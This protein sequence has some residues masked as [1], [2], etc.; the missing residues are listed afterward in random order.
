MQGN[1]P[2]TSSISSQERAIG[3]KISVG[4]ALRP[5][6]KTQVQNGAVETGPE[7][8]ESL[9]HGE[10]KQEASPKTSGPSGGSKGSK[11]IIYGTIVVVLLLWTLFW[12]N[13]FGVLHLGFLPGRG[14]S[15]SL[16]PPASE[17]STGS[18]RIEPD[19]TNPVASISGQSTL[20]MV[21]PSSLEFCQSAKEISQN[22]SFFGL[23]ANLPPGSPIFAVFDGQVSTLET[24]TP[25]VSGSEK[26]TIIYID[27][28]NILARATYIF[29]GLAPTAASVKKGDKIG[30]VGDGMRYYD[31]VSLVFQAIQ[32]QPPN[33]QIVKLS[34]K[35]FQ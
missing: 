29:R 14:K 30:Q 20:A 22:G 25:A 5:S 24:T 3:D 31:G 19:L 32:G 11:D 35:S 18:V 21:C 2:K 28:K 8:I 26:L 9:Y 1:L 15:V 10:G 17:T 13:Y 6:Q 16:A 23:G 33:G 34:S 4:Q 27:N 12:L 7:R